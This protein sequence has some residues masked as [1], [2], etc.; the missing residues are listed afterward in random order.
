[1]NAKEA[2][3]IVYGETADVELAELI[4]GEAAQKQ[5]DERI[6]RRKLESEAEA[7][8]MA[9]KTFESEAGVWLHKAMRAKK[10]LETIT[11]ELRELGSLI[12]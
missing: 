4:Y 2:A 7:E 8:R 6:R 9:I 12:P 10:R 3:R 11:D 5:E 1:M